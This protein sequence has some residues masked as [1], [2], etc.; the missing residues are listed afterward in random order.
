MSRTIDPEKLEG[1][2][3]VRINSLLWCRQMFSSAAD[4][5]IVEK[6]DWA[7]KAMR[8]IRELADS[9][10]IDVPEVKAPDPGF[11][12]EMALDWIERDQNYFRHHQETAESRGNPG[13]VEWNR[14]AVYA[15]G[16]ILGGIVIGSYL[17]LDNQGESAPKEVDP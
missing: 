14:G 3:N 1:E 7:S 11:N 16:R 2:I 15:L 17:P 8:G 12:K 10:L 9:G 13:L 4:S 6:I 5:P